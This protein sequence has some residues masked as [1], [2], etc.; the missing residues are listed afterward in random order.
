MPPV[1]HQPLQ[2]LLGVMGSKEWIHGPNTSPIS[3]PLSSIET[4]GRGAK[5]IGGVREAVAGSHMKSY[6]T[7]VRYRKSLSSCTHRIEPAFR[8]LDGER[9]AVGV[10]CEE[11]GS[12]REGDALSPL[13][14]CD[15]SR[16]MHG[17]A[18]PGVCRQGRPQSGPSSP[19]VCRALSSTE[20]AGGCRTTLAQPWRA[21]ATSEARE[22]GVRCGRSTKS[23]F[24]RDSCDESSETRNGR[25]RQD[26]RKVQYLRSGWR[27][28]GSPD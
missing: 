25:G 13:W 18:P 28:Q 17:A 3:S 8:E 26:N 22:R 12:R 4:K 9:R 11:K 21:C 19:A 27:W 14:L 15:N 1:R 20:V 23:S 24:A 16:R 2:V 6:A 5:T 7:L 10:A